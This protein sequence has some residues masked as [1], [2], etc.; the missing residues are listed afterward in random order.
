MAPIG[1]RVAFFLGHVDGNS[2]VVLDPTPPIGQG[3]R[4][5]HYYLP[6]CS[7]FKVEFTYDDPREIEI[8]REPGSPTIGEP[9]LFDWNGDGTVETPAPSPINWQS[10][11]AN[12]KWVWSKLSP[13]PNDYDDGAGDLRDLT[14]PYRWPKAIR[15]TIKVYD[16][17]GRL[18]EPITQ[19]IVHAWN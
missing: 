12:E 17:G 4:L 1:V 7:E 2:R 10:V 15:I 9:I 6:A 19:T 18:E 16:P 3:E 8:D 13:Q 5:A 14:H 11:P